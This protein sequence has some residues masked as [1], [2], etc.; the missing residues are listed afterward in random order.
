[1]KVKCE[2]N[3]EGEFSPAVAVADSLD[4][5]GERAL[6]ASALYCVCG[7]KNQPTHGWCVAI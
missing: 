1:M 7:P 2:K 6:V 5:G 3:K 4:Y